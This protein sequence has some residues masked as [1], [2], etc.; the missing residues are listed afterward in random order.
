MYI[1]IY[2][3]SGAFYNADIEITSTPKHHY[4]E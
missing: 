4:Y 1:Y 3:S 2:M